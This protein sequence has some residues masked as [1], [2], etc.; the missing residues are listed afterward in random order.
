MSEEIPIVKKEENTLNKITDL[1]TTI[2]IG[3]IVLYQMGWVYWTNY[4]SVLDIDASFIE[5]PF[6]KFITTTWYLSLFVFFSFLAGVIEVLNKKGNDLDASSAIFG[7]SVAITMILST[8]M[9]NILFIS[10][11]SGL[12]L[13][14]ILHMYLSSKYN[15]EQKTVN[16]SKFIYGVLVI[17]YFLCFLVYSDKAKKDANEVRKKFKNQDI[18]ITFNNES[19][20]KGKFVFYMNSKYFILVKNK[21]G[22][23]ETVVLNDSEIHHT[24][25]IK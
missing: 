21:K 24:R 16:K 13:F 20:A 14:F 11:L 23:V 12:L 17:M 7:V 5:M 1:A 8:Y 3:G 15:I 25:F 19:K 22:K 4:F 18:E 10:I 6:E 2:T 9:S